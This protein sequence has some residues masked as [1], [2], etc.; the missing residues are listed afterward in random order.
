MPGKKQPLSE[1]KLA[2]ARARAQAKFRD[3]PWQMTWEEWWSLWQPHWHQRGMSLD[4]YCMIRKNHDLPWSKDN[5]LVIQ[6]EQYLCLGQ[7]WF[8]MGSRSATV[9][10]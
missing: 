1:Q 8:R 6:R 9:S 2:F 5:A 3:E 4:S 10:G 7:P